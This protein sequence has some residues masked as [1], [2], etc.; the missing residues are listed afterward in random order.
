MLACTMGSD[1]DFERRRIEL[2]LIEAVDVSR[3]DD[4]HVLQS[5]ES[6]VQEGGIMRK[7]LMECQLGYISGS[8]LFVHGGIM[9]LTGSNCLGRIPPSTSAFERMEMP[10]TYAPPIECIATWIDQLNEWYRA[11][12]E[13]WIARPIFDEL[14]RRGTLSW[15]LPLS[16]DGCRR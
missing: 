10:G 9:S 14:N 4:T 15:E 13:S 2:A 12:L 5:Y 1:G 3:I 11:Q 8:T 7:Y 16:S 6:S